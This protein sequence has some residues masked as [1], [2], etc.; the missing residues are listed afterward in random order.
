MADKDVQVIERRLRS[1]LVLVAAGIL[2]GVP[3]VAILW[4]LF[5]YYKGVLADPFWFPLIVMAAMLG[6]I[7][8]GTAVCILAERKIAGYTQDR[9]GPNRVGWWGLLQPMADGLKFL[10]KE[11]IT[12]AHVDRP[13]FYLAPCLALIVSLIGFAVIPWAGDVRWPWMDPSAPAIR[14]QV[15]SLNV[16]VLYLMA[17]GSLGVYGIVLAGYASNNKYSF[18]GGMRATA[19]MISY[20]VPLGLA[21]L[22]LLL[23]AGT[24]RPEEIVNQQARSG[25]WY[26]F[27]QP[28]PFLLMLVSAFAETNRTPFDLAEAEQELVGGYHTEYSSMKF[29][30]FFLAEYAH[31]IT[32]SALLVALFF[33]GWAPLPFTSMLADSTAW[34]AMLVKLG[35][36]FAKVGVFIGLFMVIRW[37]IPRFRF[38]QLMRIAWLGMVPAG[39]AL[40]AGTAFLTALKLQHS[41]I[42]SLGLN[43][44]VL[45]GMLASAAR[46]KRPVTGRQEYLRDADVAF[47]RRD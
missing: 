16:G 11:D 40:L 7:M 20:E 8:S 46:S 5:P 14:T 15:A 12:P 38:D 28:L 43:L 37:T 35:V 36:Y 25:V 4:L 47:E 1:P 33:G 45:V 29:A 39:V 32:G 41:L 31:M 34:W 17:V 42:A 3:A 30:M 13:L 2:G 24:L 10:L 21:L 6:I 9:Y 23:V 44:L 27:L 22:C 18:F 19:Q 26:V